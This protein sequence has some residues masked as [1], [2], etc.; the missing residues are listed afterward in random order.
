LDLTV[1]P[2]FRLAAEADAD[3]LLAMMREYYAYDGH[4]YDATRARLALL[5]FLREPSFGRAWLICDRNTPVGYIVLTFGYSLEYLGRDAFIDEFF[6]IPAYRGRGWGRA[7]LAFIEE[8]AR[9]SGVRAIHLEVVRAN[10]TAKEVYRRSGYS[11]HSHHLMSK[12]IERGFPKPGS[13][14]D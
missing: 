10:T 3:T 5:D 7:T 8:A 14:P 1:D 9:T 6:L 13:T 11:D 12:W 2:T 4:A